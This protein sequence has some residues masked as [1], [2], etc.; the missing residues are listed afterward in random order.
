VPKSKKPTGTD[1]MADNLRIRPATPEDAPLAA[2]L[3]FST[4]PVLFDFVFYRDK[5]KNLALINRLFAEETN[6][7]SHNCAY[8][9]ELGGRSAGLVHVVDFEEKKSG[10]RTL[11]GSLVRHMGW[12]AFLVR[13]PRFLTLDRLIPEIGN[14]AYYIQHLATLER[15]RGRGVGRSLL[16]FCETV[17]VGRQLGSLALDVESGNDDAIRLYRSF[18]FKIARKIESRVLR[19]KYDFEGLYRMIKEF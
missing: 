1:T 3:I 13:A 5:E 2:D 9:A 19:R 7:F 8:L 17:A 11:G 12:G 6:S 18:G 4:G 16:E 10:N 15:F 14:D